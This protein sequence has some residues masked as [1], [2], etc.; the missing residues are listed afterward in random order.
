[1]QRDLESFTQKK[2]AGSTVLAKRKAK[3]STEALAKKIKQSPSQRQAA[4]A[5]KRARISPAAQP[6][7]GKSKVIARKASPKTRAT[8][9]KISATP[10]KQRTLSTVSPSRNAK[11]TTG[12]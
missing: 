5:S 6:K 7:T 1:M 2:S 12:R 11:R 4:S 8:P 9:T 3:I 10:K